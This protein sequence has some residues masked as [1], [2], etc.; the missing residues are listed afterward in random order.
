MVHTAEDP[1]LTDED[2]RNSNI[3]CPD[4]GIAACDNGGECG[5]CLMEVP[6]SLQSKC[7]YGWSLPH[8]TPQQLHSLPS[9][10][11]CEAN[12]GKQMMDHTCGTEDISQ[13]G[14]A[15]CFGG[16][17]IY[18]NVHCEGTSPQSPPPPPSPPAS[19]PPPPPLAPP[20]P[21]PPL[22]A[23]AAAVLPPDGS[24]THGVLVAVLI[25]VGILTFAAIA[26]GWVLVSRRRARTAALEAQRQRQTQIIAAASEFNASV[27]FAVKSLPTRPHSNEQA[28][29]EMT[30]MDRSEC[31]VCMEKYKEGDTV[32]DLPCGHSFHEACIDAWLLG[33]GRPAPSGPMKLPGLPTCPLCKAVP[34][35]VP[36]PTLPEK[37]K[38][39]RQSV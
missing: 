5:L 39:T 26:I 14:R 30:K 36:E 13:L 10:Q 2:L 12:G 9:G 17:D 38:P 27:R 20:P 23:A 37:G 35:D 28:A 1:A 8:C 21:P 3:S 11:F 31:A 32:K 7:P 19:P 25:P 18:V 29:V 24:E 33:K 15:Y 4:G 16:F 34:V 22:L 6:L